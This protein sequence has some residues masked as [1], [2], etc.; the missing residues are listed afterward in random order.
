MTAGDLKTG[1]W[2]EACEM[3]ARAERLQRQF[4]HPVL[5]TMQ[6]ASWEPPVDIFDSGHELLIIAALPG[7]EPEDLEIVIEENALRVAGL[8]R[9]PSITRAADMQ[10]LE[11][12]YGR[13]ERRLRLPTSHLRLNR[14]ELVNG[15]LVLSMT[16]RP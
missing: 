3:I 14:S 9:L 4:F 7:V 6:M 1:M 8:R 2:I 12:P 10:R 15:C 11:I 13:F 5:S 16:K